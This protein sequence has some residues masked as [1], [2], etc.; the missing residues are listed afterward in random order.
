MSENKTKRSMWFKKLSLTYNS[1]PQKLYTVS[2]QVP[3]SK[4]SFPLRLQ[5]VME[6]KKREVVQKV[7][8]RDEKQYTRRNQISYL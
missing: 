3:L 4:I 7:F 2:A 1:I 5:N 8:M 6:T